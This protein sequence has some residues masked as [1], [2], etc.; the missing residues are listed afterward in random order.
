MELFFFFVFL[1]LGLFVVWNVVIP[2]IGIVIVTVIGGI[3][4]LFRS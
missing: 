4:S 2:L 1:G 3:A